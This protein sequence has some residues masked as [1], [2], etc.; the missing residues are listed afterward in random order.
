MSYDVD[1]PEEDDGPLERSVLVV[2]LETV[3]AAVEQ[4]LASA[5]V[6]ERIRE[7]ALVVFA[8][9]PNVGKS[10]LFNALLGSERALVTEI[11]GTTRDTIEASVDVEGWPVR[12]ADT[13]GLWAAPGRLDQLGIEVSRRYLDAADL[14]RP[15][16][17]GRGS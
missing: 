16:V 1:F 10:S 3:L 17:C 4:L 7:G 8:G 15:S 9:R 6:G 5:P 12:F 2:E 14:I 11:P 13:A